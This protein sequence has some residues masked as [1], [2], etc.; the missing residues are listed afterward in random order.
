MN[1]I[2]DIFCL[3]DKRKFSET[4]KL[5]IELLTSIGKKS[6]ITE[7]EIRAITRALSAANKEYLYQDYFTLFKFYLSIYNLNSNFEPYPNSKFFYQFAA[8]NVASAIHLY[9][10]GKI[11]KSELTNAR[12]LMDA[13]VTKKQIDDEIHNYAV[14]V[15]K[16]ADDIDDG[17]F[18]YYTVELELPFSLPFK[19]SIISL[20]DNQYNIKKVQI[21]TNKKDTVTS[22]FGD[23]YFSIIKFTVKGFTSTNAF[24]EGASSLEKNDSNLDLFISATNDIIRK[25]ILIHDKINIRLINQ[26]DINALPIVQYNGEGTKFAHS[27]IWGFGCSSAADILSH[28]KVE[29]EKQSLILNDNA[30]STNLYEEILADALIEKGR[31]NN[32]PSF[33]LLNAS[34]EAMIEFYLL[35]FSSKFDLLK[36]TERFLSGESACNSCKLYSKYSEELGSDEKRPAMAPSVFAQIKELSNICDIKGSKKRKLNKYVSKV[37]NDKLRNK[38]IHG[39][40]KCIS[41][42]DLSESFKSFNL[43]RELFLEID[44]GFISSRAESERNFDFE[45]RS[46]EEIILFINGVDNV[47]EQDMLYLEAIDKNPKYHELI[48]AYSAFLFNNGHAERGVD[49]LKKSMHLSRNNPNYLGNYANHLVNQGEFLKAEEL[50][51]QALKINPKHVNNLGNYAYLLAELKRYDEAESMYL[52]SIL[53]NPTHSSNIYSYACLLVRVGKFKDANFFFSRAV[54]LDPSNKKYSNDYKYFLTVFNPES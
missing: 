14:E 39:K 27:I 33:Y 41:D 21:N 51:I 32:T 28:N 31:S 36:T 53:I 9:I 37:R 49:Y 7:K 10:Q 23:R 22:D 35:R 50:L 3:Y 2:D 11:D 19:D 45:Y 40:E 1:E 30:F 4:V 12:S 8:F 26:S 16:I 34:L 24:W 5:G 29:L 6:L 46:S 47:N 43:I 15:I 18:P 25:S 48:N 54:G 44:S 13:L 17:I 42:T 38:L 20:N 52:E